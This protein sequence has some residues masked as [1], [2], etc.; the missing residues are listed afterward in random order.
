MR[1]STCS[2]FRFFCKAMA[3][4]GLLKRARARGQR[5]LTQGMVLMG[6]SAMSKSRGNVV[7]PE[8]MVKRYG[9]DATRI[10]V[11]F[12]APP[13][14]DFEWDEGGIEGC[15]RFLSRTW[16]IIEQSLE[17]IE[18][19]PSNGDA[20][21][22]PDALA[23][24]RRK[25]HDTTRRVTEEIDQRLH[26]NT[27]VAALMELV[28]ECYAA[29]AETPPA[30][31]G[32][33]VWVYRDAFERLVSL[34]SPFAPHIV[35]ELWAL[36]GH[37]GYVL[38]HPWP[39]YDAAVLERETVHI[40]VQ[41]DGKVRGTVEVPAELTDKNVLIE[42]ALREPNVARHLEEKTLARSVVVPGKIISLI[43][44]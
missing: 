43:T 1:S 22:L 37:D 15:A 30:E 38:D 28:N 39:T 36:L 14:R 40:A 32:E 17:V 8:N 9:A 21:G 23:R 33:H 12:A 5:L 26:F 19:V 4:L 31:A 35:Q 25:A 3:D 34:L 10:F 44:S 13:E 2:T 16:T 27:A 24:L 41:V 7:D 11:L 6:G 20:E 18:G 42:E 29:V